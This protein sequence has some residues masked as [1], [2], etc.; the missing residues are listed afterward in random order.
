MKEV[1]VSGQKK[2]KILSFPHLK[3]WDGIL[4]EINMATTIQKSL[5]QCRKTLK[6]RSVL[7]LRWGSKLQTLDLNDLL[8]ELLKREF[9]H[10]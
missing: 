9:N 2:D 8:V 3:S 7:K 10:H 1:M 6:F 5:S 4:H